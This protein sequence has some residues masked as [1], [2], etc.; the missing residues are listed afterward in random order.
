MNLPKAPSLNRRSLI[1]FSG[2]S[3]ASNEAGLYAYLYTMLNV[4]FALFRTLKLRKKKLSGKHAVL[5]ATGLV[6]GKSNWKQKSSLGP[7]KSKKNEVPLP[8]IM[9]L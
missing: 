3:R 2:T 7:K 6:S 1:E 5:S 4:G 8:G 9:Y